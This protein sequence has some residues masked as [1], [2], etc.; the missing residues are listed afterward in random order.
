VVVAGYSF[1]AGI[2]PFAVNRLPPA[3]RAQ[4]VQLSLLGLGPRAPFEF[5][6]SGWLGQVGVNVDPYADAPLVLPEFER[7]DLARVQCFYGEDEPDTLCRAPEL[8]AAERI[9]TR[10]GH[11]FDGDYPALARRILDGLRRRSAEARP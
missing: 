3:E 10:G 9:G 7:I 8:A 5:H 11:H 4:V 1:G 6:V 2:V